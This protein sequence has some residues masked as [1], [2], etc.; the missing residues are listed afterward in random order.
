MS[1]GLSQTPYFE[2]WT[3]EPRHK[4]AGLAFLLSLL[5]PG[6]GQL[7]CNK[8]PR[9]FTT[10][11]FFA[12]SVALVFAG[13]TD[14]ARGNGVLVA[15]VLWL[16]AFL[17]AYFTALEINSGA[18]ELIDAVN[19]RVAVV[20]NLLTA[21]LGYFYLGE[22]TKGMILF[23]LINV[24]KA[25]IGATTGFWGGVVSLLGI[26]VSLVM[27][28]DAY[29][30]AR[31][32]LR[33]ARGPVPEPSTQPEASPPDPLKPASRLPAFVPVGLACLGGLGLTT[34]LVLGLAIV[35]ARG[36][37]GVVAGKLNW[38][39]ALRSSPRL[40]GTMSAAQSAAVDHFL[41]AIQDIRKVLR[42]SDRNSDDL[43]DLERD[44]GHISAAMV[45]GRLDATDL[46]VAYFYRGEASRLI[47]SIRKRQGET[48]DQPLAQ[49][50]LEDLN[51]VI[52]DNRNTYDPVVSVPNA[53]Y[54]AGLVERND[55]NSKPEAYAYWEKCAQ[56][57][58]AGCLRNVA[59][60]RITGKDARKA[61]LHEAITL[62]TTVFNTGVRYRC[63]GASSA[64]VIAGIAYFTGVR[65]STDDELAW[66]SKSYGLMDWLALTEGNPNVCGRSGA[67][68]EEFL[69]R[70]S[71]GSREDSLLEHATERLD[72]SSIAT[73]ALIQYLSGSV[74]KNGF[75]AVVESDQS[76]G[77]RCSAYFDAMWYAAL[78]KKRADAQDYHQRMSELG[79][80]S[81]GTELVFANKFKL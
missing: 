79:E 70:L 14:S 39:P 42:K 17:D 67:V 25:L 18:G 61:D 33:E 56:K 9:G 46:T 71:R 47:N 1:L 26:T 36:P 59:E 32:Q 41:G 49:R 24:L 57:G 3:P 69:Y 60:A 64:R 78:K 35:A 80:F 27:A 72:E 28:A 81:C 4:S 20:L 23:L 55:L 43:A 34:M 22:R 7:Y 12:G 58:H 31:E 63:A 62:L 44:V 16:F 21:G 40:P 6:V 10:L 8:I 5:L 51:R 75:E 11:G 74:D 38:T 19:P 68:V 13:E 15:L 29:R 48:I 77:S 45:S 30:L 66:L 50:A 73:R 53:Q 2:S 76:E 54:W 52:A 37:A 65:S